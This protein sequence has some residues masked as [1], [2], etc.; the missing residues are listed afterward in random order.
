MALG[1]RT[2][3]ALETYGNTYT[4]FSG[5]DITCTFNNVVVGSIAGLTW[6]VTREKAPVFTIETCGLN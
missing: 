4:T 5:A 3:T 2:R 6:S 1:Q